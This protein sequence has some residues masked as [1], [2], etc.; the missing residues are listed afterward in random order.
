MSFPDTDP[1]RRPRA[2]AGAEVLALSLLCFSVSCKIRADITPAPAN[3]PAELVALTGASVMIGVGDIAICGTT[4]DERTAHIVDSLL[5]ADSVAKVDDVVFTLGD[6]TYPDGSASSFAVCFAESWGDS[7]KRILKKIR[8]APG[9]HE[10]LSNR[11]APYYQ[12]FGDKAGSPR[13][14]YYSYD[15]GEWHVVVI[16]S[17]IIVNGVFNAAEKK[18]QI[19]WLENDLKTSKPCTMAY[20]HHPRYSSGSHGN[21]TQIQPLWEIL[22]KGGVDLVMAGHD[23]HYERFGPMNAYGIADTAKGMVSYVVGTGGAPLSGFRTTLAPS[24]AYRIQGYFGV[25][26]LTLGKGAFNAAFIDVNGRVWDP[27]PGKCLNGE[28]PTATDPTKP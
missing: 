9:N 2:R 25:L 15:V 13:K 17:E 8:P 21:N 12:Y 5:R 10:H 22:H 4:G 26:K 18:E 7:N 23:H 1:T 28:I 11:A 24:S 6:N 27:Y 20:F 19:D 3:A 16:N 14:G